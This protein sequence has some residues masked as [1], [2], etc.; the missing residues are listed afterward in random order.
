M[1]DTTILAEYRRLKCLANDANVLSRE[2][3][4]DLDWQ[5]IEGGDLVETLLTSSLL[6]SRMPKFRR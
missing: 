4:I 1:N 5:P 2:E 6:N 3:A